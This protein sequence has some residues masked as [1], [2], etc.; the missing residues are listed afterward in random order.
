MGEIYGPFGLIRPGG[1]RLNS[2]GRVTSIPKKR[3][4][5]FAFHFADIM[6]V[7]NVRQ[8]WKIHHPDAPGLRS[9]YDSSLWESR[10]LDSPESL[11]ELIRKGVDY[12]SAVC[13]LV[14]SET[15]SRRWVRYEIARAV[16]DN[17]GLAA[18]HINNIKHHQRFQRDPLG[19]NP[20]AYMGVGK[21]Q[22]NL[23]NE[24]LGR[25]G[26]LGALLGR[27]VS[28][29]YLF[30]LTTGR[31]VRYQDH[32]VPVN[33]PRYLADPSPGYVMPLSAGT[34]VYDYVAQQGHMN[35]GIW[36]DKAA[37]RVGR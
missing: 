18:V 22:T 24:L 21:V 3:K 5:Y 2:L 34:A 14:G 10:Q 32:T 11:K 4:A 35:I 17:R 31:W 16:I 27:G 9:F 33:L 19:N 8:A 6:R 13:V 15:W 37:E 20:L 7:N 30:E 1:L 25:V 23:Q 28:T 29:Y 12:T 36:I 26:P